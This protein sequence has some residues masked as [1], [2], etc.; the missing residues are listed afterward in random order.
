MLNKIMTVVCFLIV[1]AVA[2]SMIAVGLE[3]EKNGEIVPMILA[4]PGLYFFYLCAMKLKR[5]L[6][7]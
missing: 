2:A 4:L 5:M 6:T 7:K 1:A 3:H